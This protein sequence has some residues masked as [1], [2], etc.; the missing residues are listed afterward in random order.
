MM[1][2]IICGGREYRAGRK[3]IHVLNMIHSR[4]KITEVIHGAARGADMFGDAWAKS[5]GIPVKP[6]EVRKEDWKR[7][8][9]Y[10]G[11]NRNQKM[12]DYVDNKNCV[13]IAFPGGNGTS[14]TVER[15]NKVGI[16]VIF[17]KQGEIFWPQSII[18]LNQ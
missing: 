11:F 14:D 6:F 10:A 15:C 18:H 2:A 13:C 3:D 9:G 17:I 12:V 16:P 7:M 5:R 1:Q 4:L 8:P